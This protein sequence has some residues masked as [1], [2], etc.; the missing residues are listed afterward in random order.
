M[1]KELKSPLFLLKEYCPKHGGDKIAGQANGHEQLL[2]DI[3]C[4]KNRQ[5][6]VIT[7]K[8]Y[9]SKVRFF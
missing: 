1:E 5:K 9:P 7:I 4:F 6:S 2:D 8:R 3:F